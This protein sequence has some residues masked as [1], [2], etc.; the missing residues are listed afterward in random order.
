M[1]SKMDLFDNSFWI[2]CLR[3]FKQLDKKSLT[4]NNLNDNYLFFM[5]ISQS[6]QPRSDAGRHIDYVQ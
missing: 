5:N 4:Y 1:Q 6:S 3:N 2:N